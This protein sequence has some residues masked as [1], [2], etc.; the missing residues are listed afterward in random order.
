MFGVGD[1]HNQGFLYI[2][3]IK[4]AKWRDGINM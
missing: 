3:I 2:G 4:P 1:A